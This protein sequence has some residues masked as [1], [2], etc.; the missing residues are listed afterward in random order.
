MHRTLRH[1]DRVRHHCLTVPIPWMFVAESIALV[2]SYTQAEPQAPERILRL[3]WDYNLEHP[4]QESARVPCRR[5]SPG[6]DEA[7]YFVQDQNPET[8]L[9]EIKS[10]LVLSNGARTTT[11]TLTRDNLHSECKSLRD[12]IAQ[13][14]PVSASSRSASR[15]RQ[16]QD[17]RRCCQSHKRTTRISSATVTAATTTI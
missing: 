12:L 4:H 13:T 8:Q 5:T 3:K 2:R 11:T 9:Q 14:K 10:D 17:Y 15:R 1:R 7:K 6:F 16:P